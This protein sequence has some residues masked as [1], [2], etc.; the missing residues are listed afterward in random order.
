[1]V[2]WI[3]PRRGIACVAASNCGGLNAYMA[4]ERAIREIGGKKETV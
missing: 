2:M 1:M 3:A 4:C